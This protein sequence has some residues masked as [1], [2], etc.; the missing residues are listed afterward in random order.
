MTRFLAVLAM[1][2]AL[3]MAAAAA[4]DGPATLTVSGEATASAAP[5]MATI[6]IGVETEAETAGAALEA[7]NAEASR[8][9]ESLKGAG[10]AAKD[11]Q[12][13]TLMVHPRHANMDRTRP[14]EAPEIVGYRVI[15]EVAVTIR[16]LDGFGALLDRVVEAGANRINAIRFGLTDDSELGDEARREAVADARRRA[17][18]LAEAAGVRLVRVLSVTDGGGGP[19]PM[20]AMMERAQAMDMNVPVEAGE[21]AVRASVTVVWEIAPRQE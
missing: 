17:G 16:D 20:P 18:V 6:R 9:I 1:V 12:T 15:N 14:G 21:V 10:V 11:I 5:D 8:M 3:P 7:N 13:G 2:A 4:E 19:R